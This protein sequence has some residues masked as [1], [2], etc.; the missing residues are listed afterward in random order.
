[1]KNLVVFASGSGTNFQAV[2]DAI[3]SGYLNARITGLIAG[4]SGIEA[5]ERAHNNN[6]PVKT[7]T[8]RDKTGH[9]LDILDKWAPDLIILAG[10]LQKIPPEVIEQYSGQIINIH[11]SLLPKY[12]G[13]GC[14]GK[15][16]HKAVIQ[17]NDNV[18]G[19]S[20]HFVTD[21]YDE[22]PVIDQIQVTVT[23]EDTADTLA[24][25]V[26]EKE[27]ILLPRVIKQL[28]NKEN[29]SKNQLS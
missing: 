25:K 22:G 26:L 9:L 4:K 16:V 11:P 27:H 1:M 29:E 14:Y 21:E 2:I 24:A 15:R 18:S 13:K 8:P 10:Y 23:K 6:I 7:D 20:V 19:C 3:K 28:I 5:A 12:G 17:N